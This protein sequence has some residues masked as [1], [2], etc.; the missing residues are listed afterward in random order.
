MA[1]AELGHT[2]RQVAIRLQP[3]VENLHVTRTV[4]WLNAILTVLRRGGEHRIFVVFPVTG[5]FPQD[6]VHHKRTFN[7][8]ILVL[9]QFGTNEHF[10]F[11][12]DCPAVV[13]PEHHSWRLFLHMVQVELFTDFTVVAFRGFFQALQVSVKC[14]FVCPRRT[15]NTL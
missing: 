13:M 5:F 14:F 7:F 15:V 2:Q 9:F 11:T 12:E 10:Q 3:L 6:T 1:A 8:L 4:H